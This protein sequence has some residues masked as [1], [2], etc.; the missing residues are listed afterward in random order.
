[1]LEIFIMIGVVTWFART[2]RAAGRSGFAW[3]LLGA[4]SYYVPVFVAGLFVVPAVV[5]PL[6]TGDNDG[7]IFLLAL[8]ITVGA[9][10]GCCVLC[11]AVLLA[12]I[13]DDRQIRPRPEDPRGAAPDAPQLGMQ[14]H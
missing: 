13:A 1:M 7:S 14:A 6:A 5:G 9:G 12:T 10:I 4:L 11:R 8:A 2:A 3:G